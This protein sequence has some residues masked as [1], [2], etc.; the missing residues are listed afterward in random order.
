[1]DPLRVLLVEDNPDDA[2]LLREVLTE[3][4]ARHIELVAV[5]ELRA[6]LARL[7]RE[8]FDLV[9]LDLSLPVS[10]GLDTVQRTLAQPGAP[11][12]VVLTGLE[13]DQLGA[14][15][16]QAG[17]QDYLIKGQT[18]ATL[19]L[20]CMRYA[21]ERHRLLAERIEEARVWAAL[22]R[23]GEELMEGLTHRAL[24]ERLCRVTVDV[25]GCDQTSAWMLDESA[26]A[27]VPAAASTAEQWERIQALRLPREAL[28]PFID[29]P[30]PNGAG[31]YWL[32]E[33]PRRALPEVLASVQRG[34]TSVLYLTLR[35]GG[36]L[37]GTLA[38]SYQPGGRVWGS[39]QER[40]AQGLVHLAA[41]ALDNARL[42]EELEQ[43]NTIKTYFAGTMSHELRNT[44]FA[45]GGLSDMVGEAVAAQ[46][47]ASRWSRSIGERA[48][49][50]LQ[51]IQAALELTRSEVRPTAE[52]GR[53]AVRE[54]I[55]QLAAE[56]D[57]GPDRS[58]LAIEWTVAEALPALYTDPIKLKMILKNL[59]ANAVKFTR[60][61]AVRMSVSA[62]EGSLSF[63]VADTGLGI[64]AADL[65]HLFEP[66]RQAHGAVSRRAGGSGLGLYIVGRLVDLL[67]GTIAVESV[68]DQGTTI[69]V[70]L[71]CRAPLDQPPSQ[72]A[73]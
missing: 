53:I 51:L 56:V 18:D 44:L 33:R 7:G 67:G 64:D 20:R 47:D 42:V 61:G 35:R 22:A 46:A 26:D 23:A 30:A 71:P 9:L 13:D 32:D 50:S 52:G 72:S 45:I 60:S 16:V 25:L 19:L 40:I 41:L 37:I 15:A 49:E 66:F 27:F 12:I 70:S 55:A 48:R 69:T 58:G 6:A 11:A 38:C 10:Q 14:A 34:R 59:L 57:A 29:R 4:G 62:S 63:V 21:V 31:L 8:R 65:P 43:S 36:A 1:M 24:L 68:M 2:E 73:Q 39:T 17:A 54:L 28:R 5:Q 3:I